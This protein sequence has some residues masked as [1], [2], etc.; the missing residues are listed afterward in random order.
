MA[1]LRTGRY[2]PYRWS[3]SDVAHA[4]MPVRGKWKYSLNTWHMVLGMQG[5]GMK[6]DECLTLCKASDTL[7]PTEMGR[8]GGKARAAKMTAKERKAAAVKAVTARWKGHKKKVK[9]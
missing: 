2:R 8:R 1:L 4:D 3:D 5:T 7:T 9:P 6:N